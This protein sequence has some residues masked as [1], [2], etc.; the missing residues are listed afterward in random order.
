MRVSYKRKDGRAEALP[1]IKRAIEA[2]HPE[3][4]HGG[5]RRG[6]SC[7]LGDLKTDDRFTAD[8]AVKNGQSERSH[9]E[10]AGG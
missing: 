8:T 3:T 9:V 10:G 2:L 6:P 5:D 1:P 4:K 7:Q